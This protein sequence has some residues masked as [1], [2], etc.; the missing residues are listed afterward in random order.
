M[1]P[2]ITAC[3]SSASPLRLSQAE[4][5]RKRLTEAGFGG[6]RSRS[7]CGTTA[8]SVTAPFDAVSSIG[9][10]EHVGRERRSTYFGRVL[11]LLLPKGR[12]LNHAISSPDTAGGRVPPRSFVGRYVVADGE[13]IEVGPAITA[14]QNLGFEVRDVESLPRALGAHAAGLGRQPRGGLNAGCEP[15]GSEGSAPGRYRTLR[16]PCDRSS[17]AAENERRVAGRW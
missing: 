2:S 15:R 8:T 13:L 12:F 4:L 1:R 11:T 5:A 6:I 3:R 10:S 14:M 7:G 17:S 16:S 9:M